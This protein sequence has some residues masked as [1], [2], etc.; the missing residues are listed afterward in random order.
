MKYDSD[1]APTLPPE[2]IERI[3]AL[4]R[5]LQLAL[6]FLFSE[7]EIEAH[8]LLCM[9]THE[10]GEA[11]FR[12]LDKT[13]RVLEGGLHQRRVTSVDNEDPLRREST[14]TPSNRSYG[15]QAKS[16]ALLDI[17]LRERRLARLR[18]MRAMELSEE[19][20]K[21]LVLDRLLHPEL[22]F[23]PQ[24]G[25]EDANDDARALEL[26]EEAH[27]SAG[28]DATVGLNQG[29]EYVHNESC[30]S[31]ERPTWSCTSRRSGFLTERTEQHIRANLY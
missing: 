11:H 30:M 24:S 13:G 23:A 17:V 2:D 28:M 15:A 16:A 9:Y 12:S 5:V 4:P 20:A 29:D 25:D 1:Y 22:S 6:P 3:L 8:R 27:S 19:E 31:K 14:S 10:E 18:S 7:Q 21:Y 26:L